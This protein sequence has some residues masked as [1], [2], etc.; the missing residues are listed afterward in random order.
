[1]ASVRRDKG[2]RCTGRNRSQVPPRGLS[3]NTAE[4]IKK[5]G[6][7]SVKTYL[8]KGR[9][10]WK[11]RRGGDNRGNS[12]GNEGITRSEEVLH[13]R[14]TT[15]LKGLWPWRTCAGAYEKDEKQ[16]AAE[17]NHNVLTLMSCTVCSH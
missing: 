10:H 2:L 17:R 13:G 11:E 3:K 1:M 12:R 16:G 8:R 9:K 7:T 14:V 5:G 15:H 6:C 4:N